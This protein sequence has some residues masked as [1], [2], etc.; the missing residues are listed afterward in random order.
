MK[1]LAG[2]VALTVFAGVTGCS[3]ADE[4]SS[5][6]AAVKNAA[7]TKVV[8]LTSLS[9]AKAEAAKRKVPILADFS[10][11]DWCSWCIKL[12]QEVFSTETFKKYAADNLV[13]LLVD[14]PRT[15]AQTEEIK[16][17]NNDLV[18]KFGIEGFPTILL[19]DAGGKL[20]GRTSY[21]PGGGDNYVTHLRKLLNNKQ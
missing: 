4:K 7:D 14:F 5:G 9:E 21:L 19:L 15:K 17:Q 16:K 20:L 2:L 11:S 13:L 6:S 3:G 12:D 8:W 1:I 10:G 18:E